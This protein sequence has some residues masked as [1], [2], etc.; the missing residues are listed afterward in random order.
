MSVQKGLNST[1][2]AQFVTL[3]LVKPVVSF[4]RAIVN[5]CSRSVARLLIMDSLLCS[6][7]NKPLTFFSKFNPLILDALL[8]WT[9]SMIPS[10]SV[11]MRFDCIFK[12][13]MFHVIKIVFCLH[14]RFNVV[15]YGCMTC[16]GN[17]GPLSDEV[18]EAIEKVWEVAQCLTLWCVL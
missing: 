4:V 11:F 3:P 9:L 10:V 8:I 14:C 17:S 18:S 16:I 1:S 5:W 6:W 7:G 13:L 12:S 15:G 2:G